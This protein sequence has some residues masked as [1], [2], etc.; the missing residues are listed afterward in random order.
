MNTS[1]DSNVTQPWH[2][3]LEASR[4]CSRAEKERY[5]WFL[6]WFE[7]WRLRKNLAAERKS[8]VIFWK[9]QVQSKPREQWQLD[10]WAEAMRWYTKWLQLFQDRDLDVPQSIPERVSRSVENAGCR[11]GLA[12]NTRKTYRSWAARFAAFAG[13]EQAAMD[14]GKAREFLS[15][16]VTERRVAYST[17]KQ[18]LN[19]LAFFFKDVCRMEEVDLEV[20]FQK[21]RKRIPVVLSLEEISKILDQLDPTC[22]LAAELQYGAGLRLAE[23]VEL[24]VKDIDFERRQITVRSGKGNRDRVTVLPSKLVQPLQEWTEKTR[25][26]F[27]QD[28]LQERPGVA[29]PHALERKLGKAGEDW[30]W[31]W[32]FPARK[33]S[34]DP[35]SGIQRRHHIHEKVY[36]AKLRKAAKEAGI[37]KRVTTHAL[38]HS[39]A[40][41][42]LEKGVDI[43]TLQELLG[44]SNVKTTQIY[45]HVA[46]GTSA[47]GV[48]S[49]ADGL[50]EP[51]V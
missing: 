13:S 47:T 36:S 25:E 7:R 15:H 30:S 5:T 10:N 24:R 44:H 11:R 16:L 27:E 17:Q 28:R 43:R 35:V 29:L 22:R 2:A 31:F 34:I 45:T 49:P 48:V 32:I 21:T 1:D 9:T 51:T 41:H 20:R 26:V 19:G 12:L 50:P 4:D 23:L 38:R 3:D 33:E 39:F 40:T 8:T 14:P 46:Q 18:A 6:N 42:L 37:T